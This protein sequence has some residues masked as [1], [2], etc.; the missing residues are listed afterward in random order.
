MNDLIKIRIKTG[1]GGSHGEHSVMKTGVVVDQIIGIVQ[2]VEGGGDLGFHDLP[3]GHLHRD[4][5]VRCRGTRWC[6][7]PWTEMKTRNMGL[8]YAI[9]NL[10][11]V[12]KNTNFE[13][14]HNKAIMYSALG[15]NCNATC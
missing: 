3:G 12:P 14:P 1:T 15:K 2:V 8:L 11:G 7:W 13:S 9:I 5:Q 4:A 10:Q 6:A